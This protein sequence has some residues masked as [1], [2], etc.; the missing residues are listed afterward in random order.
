LTDFSFVS[1]LVPGAPREENHAQTGASADV[2]FTCQSELPLVTD[3][4]KAGSLEV[5]PFPGMADFY[6]FKDRIIC[7]LLDPACSELIEIF[8]LGEVLSFWLERQGVPAL[9]ASAV[10]AGEQAVEKGGI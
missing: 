5:F 4:E 8:F 1:R 6:C 7:H 10:V 2:S 3:L 9:H